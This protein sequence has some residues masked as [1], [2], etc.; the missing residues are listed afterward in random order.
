VH[1]DRARGGRNGCV[2]LSGPRQDHPA[3]FAAGVHLPW[4]DVP[5]GVHQWAAGVGGGPPRQAHDLAGGF[6]PGAIALLEF[7]DG[8]D[9]FVKA[10]GT[11]LNSVSAAM[12][13]REGSISAAL[14]RSPLLPR[15]ISSY[16]DGHWVAL[17]FEAVRGRLPH[18]P[19][20]EGELH[21]ALTALGQVHH[22]LTPNPVASI[23]P[24]SEHLRTEFSGWRTLAGL[25]RTPAALDPWSV[26]HLTRLADLESGWPEASRG[27]TLIHGD[28]RSD[29]M[30]IGDDTVVFVDWPHASVGSPLLDLV[31]WAPSVTLEGGPEPE[32]LLARFPAA[33]AADPGAVTA[34]VAAVSGYFTEHA[35]RPPQPGLPTVRAFQDAQGRVARAW[36]QHRTGWR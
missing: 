6:S 28:I 5:A 36:L 22:A 30:L 9:I 8:P 33:G 14:P 35:L 15:L 25:P 18:H 4:A 34:L 23:S 16:D 20:D 11:E 24:A 26:R 3:P 27:T 31:E 13:R 10:V 12:H 1:R 17:A 7:P 21:R 29:N 2:V 19:W 32:E